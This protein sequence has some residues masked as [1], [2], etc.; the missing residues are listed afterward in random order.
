M[1]NRIAE[2]GL[3]YQYR[4]V[5][6]GTVVLLTLSL[7]NGLSAESLKGAQRKT[8]CRIVLVCHW[9]SLFL[10]LDYRLLGFSIIYYAVQYHYHVD[11]IETV[12]QGAGEDDDD[13]REILREWYGESRIK[14]IIPEFLR[15][16]INEDGISDI[17]R[18]EIERT[19]SISNERE[20]YNIST[21]SE[22]DED[23][24]VV[25]RYIDTSK[26]ASIFNSGLWFSRVDKFSDDFEGRPTEETRRKSY[27]MWEY[28]EMEGDP[29][30]FDS[31]DMDR[32]SEQIARKQSFVSSWRYGGNES[33]V[34]WD[35]YI[36]DTPGVA[37][38]TDLGNLR[39]QVGN[40][41]KKVAI[42][43]VMYRQYR[44]TRDQIKGDSIARFFR[45]RDGFEDEKELRLLTRKRLNKCSVE[46]GS[47]KSFSISI[48]ADPGFNLEIDANELID[49]VIIRPGA[50][51]REISEVVQLCDR[52]DLDAE[53]WRS[54]LD[55]SPD[56][57]API[58]VA[59][60][61]EGEVVQ[62]ELA[63]ERRINK[64]EFL[65]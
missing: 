9:K 60:E 29:L 22:A 18:K 54:R 25:R 39:S 52:Q 13:L 63:D 45:K 19:S 5:V 53:I 58:R 57:T 30:P 31:R 17:L 62:E 8:F 50:P 10:D 43:R 24:T 36:G 38:E 34:F 33:Q 14:E 49:K 61:R 51:D 12:L 6:T 23:Q 1:P 42:G 15:D 11:Y 46:L 47:G 35:A 27:D 32:A 40:S 41:S 55:V 21:E 16:K 2:T 20:L 26:L 3:G 65:A 48:S 59:G 64:S 7:V 28:S 44:G 37:I 4:E 56:R